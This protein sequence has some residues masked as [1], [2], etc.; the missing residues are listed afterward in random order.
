[1]LLEKLPV[2]ITGEHYFVSLQKYDKRAGSYIDIWKQT[3]SDDKSPL[4]ESFY[5]GKIKKIKYSIIQINIIKPISC[6]SQTNQLSTKS[7][8][9]H[10]V[11]FVLVEAK[12]KKKRK[13]K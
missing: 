1:M 4:W 7:K 8:H 2:S 5:E 13:K 10:V 3:L 6:D 12:R 9:T 11:L